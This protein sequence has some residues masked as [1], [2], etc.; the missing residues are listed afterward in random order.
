MTKLASGE[1]SQANNSA[2][3]TQLESTAQTCTDLVGKLNDFIYNSGDTLKGGGY[4][5]VRAKFSFYVDAISKQKMI[6]DNLTNNVKAA[7]NIMLTFMDGYSF[8]DDSKIND[9]EYSIEDIKS[10]LGWLESSSG[11]GKNGTA[12]EI[13]KWN[14]ILADLEKKLQKL[15]SLSPTDKSSFALLDNVSE[16]MMNF[17]Q[18]LYELK[19]P[20]YDGTIPEEQ[21]SAEFRELITHVGMGNEPIFYCQWGWWDEDGQLH[22]WKTSW[23]KSIATSGCGPTSMAAVLA[24]LLGD[25]SI[26][27]ATVANKMGYDDNVGGKYVVDNCKRYG[28]DMNYHIVLSKS[29]MNNHLR[30][31]GK[32]IVAINHGGHY[33]AVLGINDKKKPPTYIVCDPNNPKKK[34]WTYSEIAGTHTMT[35]F[36]APKGKSVNECIKS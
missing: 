10:F 32:M 4:D 13:S 23:G 9:I 21:N 11:S 27:P 15:K 18:A 6:C 19:L 3:I 28:L 34:E 17:A 1:L 22:R 20:N 14:G 24:T 12:E 2:M 5:A 8:L 31:G 33:I 26:T 35:F 30:N 16:D 29:T 25:Q 7:N 36:I